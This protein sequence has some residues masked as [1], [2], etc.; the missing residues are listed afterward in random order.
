[1]LDSFFDRSE[2]LVALD[3]AAAQRRTRKISLCA[4][5]LL[6]L[7][8]GAP[9]LALFWGAGM[10]AL[11]LL[12]PRALAAL[13]S[14]QG[15]ERLLHVGRIAVCALLGCGWALGPILGWSAA[16]PEARIGVYLWLAALLLY[17]CQFLYRSGLVFACAIG[18]QIVAAAA[19]VIWA[20]AGEP[21]HDQI[22]APAGA[23]L[24]LSIAIVGALRRRQS[25]VRVEAMQALAAAQTNAA[26]AIAARLKFTMDSLG[27]A[28]W[29]IDFTNQRI[30]GEEQISR[31]MNYSLTFA[32]LARPGGQ[33]VHPEDS[34][35][36]VSAYRAAA[37]KRGGKLD[38][39]YR[40]V[41]P[42]G[43][44]RW[45]HTLG[46]KVLG[47][48]GA[49]A[50]LVM[51]TT[52]ET[53]RKN[54]EMEFA[55]AMRGAERA[56]AD[57]RAQL[58]GG[59][60]ESDGE[61]AA[62][63]GAPREER[64]RNTVEGFQALFVRLQRLLREIDAR[65][66]A[67]TDAVAALD[68]AR[69]SAEA[70]NIA[71]SQFVANMSHELRTPL[72]AVIGYAEIL[73]EDLGEA[74][75]KAPAKDAARIRSA[76]RNLLN[77]INEILDLA[78]IEAGKME[79]SIGDV[80]VRRVVSDAVEMVGTIA[81]SHNNLIEVNIDPALVA[82]PARTDETKL[83]QCLLNLLSNACK[84]TEGGRI[85]LDAG[86]EQGRAGRMLRFSVR[87]TGIGISA[88]QLPRLFQA[89]TQADGSTTRKFG[90]T[91]LGLAIT[92]RLAQILGGDVEVDSTPGAGSTFTLT[93]LAALDQG[94]GESD[95]LGGDGPLVLIID[96]ESAARDLVRRSLA[97]LSFSTRSAA[98]GRQGLRLA[99]MLSPALILLD[100][101]LPDLSGWLVLE[102]LKS[103][104]A[105]A[106]IP[107]VVLSIEDDRGR[108]LALGAREHLLKPA[109]RDALAAAAA[110]HCKPLDEAA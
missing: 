68:G 70:A 21:L 61:P 69:A 74:G 47:E 40:V 90:G 30:V 31:L 39:E 82:A 83:R 35:Y 73:E 24:G 10:L 1:M 32:D 25:D 106:D 66:G 77:L 96:D 19:I 6:L 18:P 41:S 53:D 88:E 45:L 3:R 11:E 98:D 27:A 71:K 84:F 75:M 108:S 34:P 109:D 67:L 110:R 26:E 4:A 36:V 49:L 59:R 64:T 102:A 9:R 63:E 99:R 43:A 79:A 95:E 16:A 8:L 92:R 2:F 104:P 42:D 97:R 5:A 86:I 13:R 29:E 38:I 76:A 85:V 107:V 101:R 7:W 58:A 87:D 103:D 50:R 51:M 93:A 65:D 78:K 80:D 89:F 56:L 44:V 46:F 14:R 37:S 91:G 54:L 72:N 28:I 52:D 23:A 57:K 33:G 15:D 22:M 60:R 20:G 48:N 94:D 100:I 17:S 105:T 12:V 81:D 55:E 62:L